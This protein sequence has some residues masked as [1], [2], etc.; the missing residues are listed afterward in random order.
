MI[1]PCKEI[2]REYTRILDCV[3]STIQAVVDWANRVALDNPDE[4]AAQLRKE[5]ICLLAKSLLVDLEDFD[6]NN[7]ELSLVIDAA[8]SV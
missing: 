2:L 4:A 3:D 5:E 8:T 6:M 7:S 1:T